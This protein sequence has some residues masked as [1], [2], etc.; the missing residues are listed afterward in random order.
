VPESFA[1][2]DDGVRL[3]TR[4]DATASGVPIVLCHGGPGLWDNLVGLGVLLEPDRQVVRWEQRGCG[5]SDRVGPYAMARFVADLDCVRQHFGF[6]S[7]IVGGHSWGAALAL[8]YAL[9]HPE[10]V[11]AL[12]SVSGVGIGKEWNAAYHA[13]AD[14]R[15][16]TGQRTRRDELGDRDRTRAEEHEFRALTWTPDFA[17]RSGAYERALNEA[18]APFVTNYE[19]N[20]T[21]GAEFKRFDEAEL[22]ARCGALTA[23]AL[24]VHGADDPRP[25]WAIDSLAAALPDCEVHVLPGLGHLPWLEDAPAVQAVLR[26]FCH[27]KV[28]GHGAG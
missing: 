4:S 21:L 15:L 9:A 27:R 7:W 16:T 25:S 19:C 26:D 28:T 3:W 2:T 1:V 12:V 24:V 18:R 10:R 17:D 23:P 8:H 13:E 5:R 6:D 14:R 22:A 11:A 20:R